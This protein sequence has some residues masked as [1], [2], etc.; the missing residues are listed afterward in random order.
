LG[1]EPDGP[2]H[3]VANLEGRWRHE[4]LEPFLPQT[5]EIADFESW[6][7]DSASLWQ[8]ALSCFAH[9][10]DL[11]GHPEFQRLLDGADA[12][13]LER[14]PARLADALEDLVVYAQDTEAE[15]AHHG[16]APVAT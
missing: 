9:R 15:W 2:P 7:R 4:P 13:H 11:V 8:T 5:Q 16:Q 6:E 14:N 10:A 12:A 3:P 1:S